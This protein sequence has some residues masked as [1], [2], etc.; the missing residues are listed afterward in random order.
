MTTPR[1]FADRL[2]HPES[3]A[4]YVSAMREAP[5]V[6]RAL[7]DQQERDAKDAKDAIRHPTYGTLEQLLK[8]IGDDVR[9]GYEVRIG[10]QGALN[11]FVGEYG[12]ART[13]E[14]KT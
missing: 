1:E 4:D 12:A 14:P 8:T 7:A 9:G 6:L 5:A 13:Q 2:E 11:W 10:L 3:Y